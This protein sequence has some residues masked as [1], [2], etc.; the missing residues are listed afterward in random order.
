MLNHYISGE[1]EALLLL[2]GF[3]FNNKIWH[4]QKKFSKFKCYCVDL[5]GCGGTPWMSW[6]DFKDQLLA[7]LPEKFNILGWSLGGLYAT[8]LYIENYHKIEKIICV[9]TTPYFLEDGNWSG[10]SKTALKKL[11]LQYLRSQ[12]CAQKKF[13]SSICASNLDNSISDLRNLDILATWDFR[14]SLAKITYILGE[15]DMLVSSNNF[16]AFII[17]DAQHLPFITHSKEF[18]TI[19]DKCLK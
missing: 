18:F 15:R 3:G 1:G 8:R 6:S 2:H 5:P 17:K 14:D 10:I 12:S 13:L 11:R 7:I 16:A 4:A 9:A 19:L